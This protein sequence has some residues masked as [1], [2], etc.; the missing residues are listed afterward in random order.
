MA[1]WPL[2]WTWAVPQ[3]LACMV[4]FDAWFY[5]AHRL[6]HTKPFYRFH[7]LHHRSVA[8]TVWSN[9]SIGLV[10]T[11][12]SQGFY[13]VIVFVVPF[14]PFISCAPRL[15]PYQRHVRP[16]RLRI[17]RLADVALSLADA[18]HDLPRPAPRRV[19][20]QLRELFLF[21]GPA[22]GNGLAG[23]RHPRGGAGATAAPLSLSKSHADGRRKGDAG[24]MRHGTRA[25]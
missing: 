16:L 7:V 4:L 13:A 14:S 6:L 24:S 11:A 9:D 22:D 17:F 23:L 15:R 3:F 21:V 19:P 10:D 8:P 18:V 5:F 12:I 1:P 25:G 2:S 20:L